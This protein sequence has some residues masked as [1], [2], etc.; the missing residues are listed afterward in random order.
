MKVEN[1]LQR[2]SFISFLF[3]PP[4]CGTLQ[5]ITV[6]SKQHLLLFPILWQSIKFCPNFV[7][8][9][10]VKQI[11]KE[12][13][14]RTYVNELYDFLTLPW[15]SKFCSFQNGISLLVDASQKMAAF[16]CNTKTLEKSKSV[17][18][19]DSHSLANDIRK[20][21]TGI[22]YFCNNYILKMTTLKNHVE[23]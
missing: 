22:H 6:H 14:L 11:L 13:K 5:I 15:M 3:K 8:K 20:G 18:K 21:C 9:H 1:M 4:C 17:S 19:F 10:Q 7:Y 2:F 23:R 16:L 12:A